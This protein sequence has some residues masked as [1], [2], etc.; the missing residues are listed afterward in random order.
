[1]KIKAFI[2]GAVILGTTGASAA[3]MLKGDVSAEAG[4]R[5]IARGGG[6]LLGLAYSAYQDDREAF[7]GKHSLRI[8]QN[9]DFLKYLCPTFRQN[10]IQMPMGKLRHGQMYTL[11]FYAKAPKAFS[12]GINVSSA[13]YVHALNASAPLTKEW[14]RFHFTF[15]PKCD[16]EIREHNLNFS[17][18]T[19]APEKNGIRCY[20]DAVQLEE[21]DAVTPFVPRERIALEIRMPKYGWKN[22]YSKNERIVANISAAFLD[23]EKKATVRTTVTD[24][25]GKTIFSVEKPIGG[26]GL[27]PIDPPSD[28]Y[29]WFELKTEALVK[30][31]T[32]A[33][34]IMTY[35]V[36]KEPAK[37]SPGIEPFCGIIDQLDENEVV[38]HFADLARIGA[39]R[40]QVFT[41]MKTIEK[42][43]GIYDWNSIEFQLKNAKKHN[44]KVKFSVSPFEIPD[45]H[46]DPAELAEY[47]KHKHGYG[48]IMIRR[49]NFDCWTR[50]LHDFTVKYGDLT[51]EI[52][53]GGEDNGR[54]GM[55]KF[56]TSQY[57][58][59]LKTDNSGQP[60]LVSGPVFD[61]YCELNKLGA[62]EIRK[63][64]PRVKISSIRPWGGTSP[65]KDDW[66]FVRE[67]LKKIGKE[68]SVFPC[69]PYFSPF[70]F[71]RG[72]HTNW[73]Y[74]SR[75]YTRSLIRDLMKKYGNGDIPAFIS[76][77]GN[78]IHYYEG[79]RKYRQEQAVRTAKDMIAARAAG[80]YAYDL[81]GGFCMDDNMW[82][83]TQHHMNQPHLAAYSAVADIVENVIKTEYL[84]PDSVGRIALFRKN[85]GSGRAALWADAGYQIRMPDVM[86][87][88]CV[89]ADFMGNPLKMEQ[90]VMPLGLT[91]VYITHRNYDQ[92][93]SYA[94][95]IVFSSKDYCS[96]LFRASGE[97]SASVKFVNHS[98]IRDLTLKITLECNGRKTGDEI[99]IPPGYHITRKITDASGR[100]R[101]TA[102]AQGS[103]PIV[104][105]YE[106]PRIRPV[107][108]GKIPLS[109]IGKIDSRMAILPADPWVPW[110]G[111]DDLSADVR[112]SWDEEYLYVKAVVKDDRH[113]NKFEER[114][115][116][117]DS[118]EIAID[119][120]ND[121]SFTPR[122]HTQ[123]LGL[124]DI[125]FGIA[126]ADDG[127]IWRRCYLGKDNGLTH[128]ENSS[129]ARDEKNGLTTYQMRFP[130]KSLGVTPRKGMMIGM[131]CAVF[132]DDSG[133]GFE[134]Y[135]F[136]GFG[137][138]NGKNPALYNR[139][140]L[141]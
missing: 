52:E 44:I 134:Y 88:E 41:D 117:A 40:Y 135:G 3:N 114:M 76:E 112:A 118:F 90:A 20:I 14:R 1:M 31:E 89:I 35:C 140:I 63:I 102:S 4:I 61:D 130:W 109:Q 124:D 108:F 9:G 105:E 27:Y 122:K 138:C 94:K 111:T 73:D 42:K 119:P 128:P 110:S 17:C 131:S 115:Y 38:D 100:I 139:F 59:G 29:G 23:G 37:T 104:A 21:G 18:G 34:D 60:W 50:F 123:M 120:K 48:K 86:T 16:F 67:A 53:L 84:I 107:A 70:Y 62:Q 69:D 56:Y 10:N 26:T 116:L 57:P 71:G 19:P 93:R 7:H 96:I 85:D 136:D 99:T 98:N 92:L 11:S 33:S 74:D 127:K 43:P 47:K 101:A 49:G 129:V 30:G 77:C 79:E 121:G 22:L 12:L 28:R 54:L 87:R 25:T 68:F 137:I 125:D 13:D 2:I 80:F 51:D 95:N 75:I 83:F 65:Y 8:E 32:M 36:L 5:G 24:W 91:P 81:Y 66:L 132:D 72:K 39:K 6:A 55:N 78:A 141:K 58:A 97:K 45:W 106:F 46:A 82:G 15:S 133:K 64:N 103:E 126:L 113:Y